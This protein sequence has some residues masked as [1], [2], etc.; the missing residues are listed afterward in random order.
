MR[1]SDFLVLGTVLCLAAC[2]REKHEVPAAVGAPPSSEA[3]A[4]TAGLADAACD[5]P[6]FDFGSNMRLTWAVDGPLVATSTGVAI[7]LGKQVRFVAPS[8]VVVVRSVALGCEPLSPTLRERV[9]PMVATHTRVR[10]RG[11]VQP[12]STT[13]LA[14]G[15]VPTPTGVCIEAAESAI[16]PLSP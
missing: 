11:T 7:D 15:G 9:T 14:D 8:G 3:G 2:S 1:R 13:T 5:G 4:A 10:V 16:T 12:V 6:T